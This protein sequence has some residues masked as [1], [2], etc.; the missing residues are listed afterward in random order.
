[1][2]R[3]ESMINP[4]IEGLLDLAD[5]KFRLVTVS[6]KRARQINSYFGQ[7]GEGLGASI[8]PQITSTARKPLSIAFE[9]MDAGKIVPIEPP[10]EPEEVEGL[11]ADG[12]LLEGTTEESADD[13]DSADEGA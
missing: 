13:A 10:D 3:H 11:D 5:S 7:L 2:K 6:A 12:E 8:P 9:E 4:P 1:M